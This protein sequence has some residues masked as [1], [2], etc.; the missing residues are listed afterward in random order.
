MITMIVCLTCLILFING[1][2][3]LLNEGSIK[4]FLPTIIC[5]SISIVLLVISKFIK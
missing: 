2:I 4:T 1:C 5:G 3:C